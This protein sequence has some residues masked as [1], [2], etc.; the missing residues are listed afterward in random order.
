MVYGAATDVAQ[1]RQNKF[2]Q[3]SEHGE[4]VAG[5]SEEVLA[6][7]EGGIKLG[8]AGLDGN[9][10]IVD[11]AA[12][13]FDDFW[14]EVV[15]TDGYATGNEGDVVVLE[16]RADGIGELRE[17]VGHGLPVVWHESM[18]MEGSVNGGT[19]G[20]ANLVWSDR[21]GGFLEFGPRGDD[22]NRG[23]G[24]HKRMGTAHGSAEGECAGVKAGAC[25]QERFA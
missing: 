4:W 20:I 1:G 11:G 2:V 15:F 21:F 12:E 16:R 10:M 23:H 17:V 18:S 14:N 9:A 19:I 24:M 25:S 13:G 8:F 6:I 22:G 5:E 3:S 7:G